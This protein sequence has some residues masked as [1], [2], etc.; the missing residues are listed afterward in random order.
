MFIL[1]SL[2]AQCLAGYLAQRMTQDV[3]VASRKED[4]KASLQYLYLTRSAKGSIQISMF[5]FLTQSLILAENASLLLEAGTDVL[6]SC[7]PPLNIIRCPLIST[8]K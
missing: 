4:V 1:F 6:A 2:C 5:G 8:H 3:F 7:I